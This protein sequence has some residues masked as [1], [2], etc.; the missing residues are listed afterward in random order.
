MSKLRYEGNAESPLGKRDCER[1]GDLLSVEAKSS[2]RCFQL[3][4]LTGKSWR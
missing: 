3:H 2:L 1:D 4:L